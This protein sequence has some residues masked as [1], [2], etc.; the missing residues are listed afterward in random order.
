MIL[1]FILKYIGFLAAF[2]TTIAFVPQA[3][4][5]WKTRSTKDISLYMFIIFT[6]GVFSWLL[7][8]IIISDLPI[9]LANAV[10]LILSLFILVFKLK[11]K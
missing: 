10:T 3:L 4:K 8:G 6:F 5:V 7:Y 2:C 1:N 11:Y 9:I